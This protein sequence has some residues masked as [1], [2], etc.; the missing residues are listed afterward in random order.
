MS[1]D[2]TLANESLTSLK[3]THSELQSS[4]SCLTEKYKTLEANFSSLWESTKATLSARLDY[5]ASTSKGCSIRSNIDINAINTNH[6]R[7]QEKIKSKD[8]EI[9]RLNMLITQGN[10][11]AK[12]IPKVV[13]KQGLGHRKNNNAN[14]RVVVKGQEIP[15]WNKGAYLKTIRD[16]AHGVTTSTTTKDMP[17][18]VNT[19]KGNGGGD[20]PPKASKNVVEHKPSPNY[21]CDYIVT[22]DHNGKMVVKYVGAYTMKSMRKS[23][24]VPK[25]Y[26]SNLQ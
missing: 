17:K 12:P 13:N 8:K 7:L 9:A 24:W 14:G 25:V 26:A 16:I 10:I 3:A 18:V 15:L 2:F 6:A 11:G 22:L 20:T 19:T 5:S 4:L 21:T 23:V 1:K